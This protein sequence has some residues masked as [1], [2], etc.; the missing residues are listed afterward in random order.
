MAQT[1][2]FT[3]RTM[4]FTS[5]NV[6]NWNSVS[7]SRMT[8]KSI[9]VPFIFTVIRVTNRGIYL[10]NM[11]ICF[12]LNLKFLFNFYH[13]YIPFFINQKSIYLRR[14]LQYFFKTFCIT[15]LLKNSLFFNR[16]VMQNVLNRIVN[17]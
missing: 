9:I 17:C 3:L 2:V 16:N 5:S 4:H 12:I 14:K 11:S 8:T 6:S 13:L 15:F 1:I 7:F 10:K